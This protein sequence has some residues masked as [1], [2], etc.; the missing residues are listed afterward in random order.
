MNIP[1]KS[2]PKV[3]TVNLIDNSNFKTANT[4]H[5]NN[6]NNDDSLDDIDKDKPYQNLNSKNQKLRNKSIATTNPF[7]KP[8]HSN[9]D[10]YRRSRRFS[11]TEKNNFDQITGHRIHEDGKIRPQ[12]VR[13]ETQNDYFSFNNYNH[14]DQSGTSPNKLYSRSHDSNVDVGINFT[15]GLEDEYI[16]GLDFS[17]MVYKWNNSSNSELDMTRT[18]TRTNPNSAY[19]S[20]SNTPRSNNASYLDLNL[21]HA[22]VAPQPI[23]SNTQHPSKLSYSKLHDYMKLR[24]PNEQNNETSSKLLNNIT[25][26]DETPSPHDT[27]KRDHFDPDNERKS[28]KP[29][30]AVDPKTGNINYELILNSLP[31]NF[32]DLPYSQR[33]KLVCN[34]SESIDYSQFSLFAKNYFGSV[35]GSSLGKTPKTSAGS[36]MGGF[37][38]NENSL[39]RKQRVGSANTLAGR[40]LARTS[41]TDVRK[42]GEPKQKVN[43]DERGALVLDHEIGKIIGF[44]AWGTIR[45]CIDKKGNVRAMKIVKSSRD[46]SRPSSRS[47]SKT[48]LIDMT[49]CPKVLDVFRKEISIW[50]QLDHPNILP[51]IDSYETDDAIFC[52]MNRING[53]TLFELVSEWGQFNTG[54]NNNSGPLKFSIDNQRERLRKVT[55]CTKQIVD[56]LLYMHE[57]KGIV[58]GD[59]K[60]ENVLVE[61]ENNNHYKMI[62]CDFGMSRIYSMRLSRKS[63]IRNVPKTGDGNHLR[64]TTMDDDSNIRSKSSNTE[65]RKPYTGG[66]TP[67]TRF[68]DFNV[69]DDSRVGL[70]NF[71]KMHGPSMQSVHLTPIASETQSPTA[72]SPA[73]FFEFSKKFLNKEPE[74]NGIDSELP[75]SHIGSLPYASPELLQPAPPPLGPSAD[76]WALG[77]LIYAMCCGKLPFQHQ[78]EPR[79]RAMITAGQYNKCDLKKACL[80]EWILKDC[81]RKSKEEDGNDEESVSNALSSVVDLQR[82]EEISKLHKQWMNEKS[83]LIQEFQF[84]FDIVEGCLE[85]NITKRF[86]MQLVYDHLN[87]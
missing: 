57:E 16:P 33:K 11:E 17:D 35:G 62:L 48:D 20:N 7:D 23:R 81:S 29:K 19:T 2:Q 41:T 59:L 37:S 47:N 58:H 50:K 71:F 42:F 49:H 79:L 6:D 83:T 64:P 52:I 1:L 21:L 24:N 73:D 53:G 55:E 9:Y 15:Q 61:N 63:S 12:T 46:F 54:I 70:S 30:S 60:L 68:L 18:N 22:Q 75:H 8:E 25:D 3:S 67:K 32:N 85:P 78:Y 74:Q 10:D 14:Q 56:A 80:L 40:L 82:K 51:L 38:S 28:K 34:F 69:N 5:D 44:G 65:S 72:S 13:H 45:E 31:P 86:D 87:P 4:I 36:T 77:V 27:T 66:D 76:V 26:P 39:S 84:L 43:V